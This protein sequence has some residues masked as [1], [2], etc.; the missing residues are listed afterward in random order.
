MVDG[1]ATA[2]DVRVTANLDGTECSQ[3]DEI[4]LVGTD[5]TWLV[6]DSLVT[7]G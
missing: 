6:G 1:D 2:Y 5:G 4:R 3:T 7:A